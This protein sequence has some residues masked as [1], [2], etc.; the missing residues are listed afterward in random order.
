MKKVITDTQPSHILIGGDFNLPG[1]DWK[2]LNAPPGTPHRKQ[3][4]M[5]NNFEEF[6]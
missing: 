5:I 1:V 2:N 4:K 6:I 3:A